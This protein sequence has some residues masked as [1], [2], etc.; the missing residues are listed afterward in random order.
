MG[1]MAGARAIRME[2]RIGTL[3]AGKRADIVT[4]DA[5]S[6][7]RCVV[8]QYDPVTAIVLHARQGM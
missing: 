1:T 6:P 4:F 7:G 3:A 2:D 5:L 8:A